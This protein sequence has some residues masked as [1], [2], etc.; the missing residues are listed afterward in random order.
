MIAH[1]NDLELYYEKT[2]T[3]KTLVMLHGNG[4]DH[5]IFDEAV[6]VLKQDFM[7]YCIDSRGHGMSSP[8]DEFHYDDMADD[9]IDFLDEMDL[10]DVTLYGF[11]DGGIIG[12]IAAAKCDRIKNLI[13]SGANLDPGG[14]KFHWRLLFRMMYLFGRDPKIKLMF[15]EPDI[16]DETL[17]KIRAKTLV[18]AGSNDLIVEKQ[19][20]HIAE[21][22]PGAELRIMD[23]EDHGSYIIHKTKIGESI[24]DFCSH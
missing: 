7:C 12:L 24:R 19:T 20:R 22:I 15:R 14:V 1:I 17:K 23:G 10:S 13:I 2:G 11:S 18:L 4:E 8:V 9:V 16:K 3:G 5:S 21:T 6:E